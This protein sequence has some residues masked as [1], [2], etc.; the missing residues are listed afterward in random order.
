MEVPIASICDYALNDNGKLLLMGAFDT[1][2]V[3]RLPAVHPYCSIAF[4]VLL[5]NRDPAKNK[6]QVEVLDPD[7]TNCIP[8]VTGSFET[9]LMPD[10]QFSSNNLVINLV[11]LSLLKEGRYTIQLHLNDAIVSRIPL[12][13]ALRA[14]KISDAK[15]LR[16]KA[17]WPLRIAGWIWKTW[18]HD[19]QL[20][21]R[22]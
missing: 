21:I 15:R 1:I 10:P 4:R 14:G 22:R 7:G 16:Q 9:Q 2:Y 18:A 13:V 5:T 8:P 6:L 20:K 17:R 11:H 3:G 19:S 12:V